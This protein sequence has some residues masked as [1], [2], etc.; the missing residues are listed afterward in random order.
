MHA[1]T[2]TLECR[3]VNSNL[4]LV[5]ELGEK[6]YACPVCPRAFN[7]RV[8]LRE[9]IRSHH[10]GADPTYEN[11]MTPYFCTV[12]SNAFGT[13]SEIIQHLIEHSDANT[14]SKRQPTVSSPPPQAFASSIALNSVLLISND[15]AHH[16]QL[17]PRK[18]KRRRKLKPEELER[19]RVEEPPSKRETRKR[20]HSEKDDLYSNDTFDDTDYVLNDNYGFTSTSSLSRSKRDRNPSAAMTAST[21]T[22]RVR[23]EVIPRR[24][25][26]DA[27]LDSMDS[28][29][30]DITPVSDH[31]QSPSSSHRSTSSRGASVSRGAASTAATSSAATS[32]TPTAR[33]IHTKKK[34]V[35]AKDGRSKGK[36]MITQTTPSAAERSTKS[37]PKTAKKQTKRGTTTATNKALT[38][39]SA[40]LERSDNYDIEHE[41]SQ[42]NLLLELSKKSVNYS[43]DVVSDLEEILRSPIKSREERSSFSQSDPLG[44]NTLSPNYFDQVTL[45][46][47]QRNTRSSKRLSNRNLTKELNQAAAQVTPSTSSGG[48]KSTRQRQRQLPEL[49]GKD[50]DSLAM[51]DIAM[52]IK[53]EKEVSY[54]LNDEPPVVYTCEMCAAEFSDRAQL[55]VHVPVHI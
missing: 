48:G 44:D 42:N 34:I 51:H 46:P 32:K 16:S 31:M 45:E 12:C 39:G 9:H 47:H 4:F 5:R 15:F 28:T 17:G 7:Q 52:H 3:I 30:N 14:I 35:P 36:T 23:T 49:F 50:N 10:S 6:P 20:Q 43:P 18:Y 11:T 38:N 40:K 21:S 33:M 54:T 37:K 13:P 29:L 2:A 26:F 53:Q 19:L 24:D 55:L 41:I 22:A 27:V 25:S 8:V 1:A